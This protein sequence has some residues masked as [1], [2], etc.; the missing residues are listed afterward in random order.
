MSLDN[1]E[2]PPENCKNL[3]FK[4]VIQITEEPYSIMDIKTFTVLQKKK[5]PVSSEKYISNVHSGIGL[6]ND[7]V[8]E[9]IWFSLVSN[10]N[11]NR[12]GHIFI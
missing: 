8:S 4:Q 12:A 6:I 10:H 7:F 2:I 3:E 5:K 1:L 11:S 9:V